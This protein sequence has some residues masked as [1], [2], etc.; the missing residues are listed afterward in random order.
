MKTIPVL[1]GLAA[2]SVGCLS[3]YLASPHQRLLAVA[4][5]ARPARAGGAFALLLSWLA[6]AQGLQTLAAT[7]VL[8]TQ[9]ML[10]FALLPYL[11]AWRQLRRGASA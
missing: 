11:G 2:C 4:W 9:L 3:I 5:P 1:L 10:L 7:Y 8:I 6:F